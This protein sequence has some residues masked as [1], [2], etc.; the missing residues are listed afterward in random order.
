LSG[1]TA[2]YCPQFI[3]K[4]I[5]VLLEPATTVSRMVTIISRSLQ[6]DTEFPKAMEVGI[7]NM[8]G[9]SWGQGGRAPWI[10]IHSTHRV[11]NR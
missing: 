10:F 3:V 1:N 8:G 7:T 9:G 5:I 4:L 2:I 11:G 6:N